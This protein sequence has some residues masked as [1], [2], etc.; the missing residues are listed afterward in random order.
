M[1]LEV[2]YPT[3]VNVIPYGQALLVFHGT[4]EYNEEGIAIGENQDAAKILAGMIKQV[5]QQVQ[6]AYTIQGPPV[7]QLPKSQNLSALK[8][9]YNGQIT[10]LQS[11]FKLK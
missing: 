2:I 11:Q 1:N 9:K 7:T 6:S 3:S 5:N 8:G 10:K 4:M